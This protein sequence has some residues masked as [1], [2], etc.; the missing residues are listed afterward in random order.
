V[1]SLEAVHDAMTRATARAVNLAATIDVATVTAVSATGVSVTMPDG[2]SIPNV[3]VLHPYVA[4][5]GDKVRVASYGNAT[6]VLGGISVPNAVEAYASSDSAF[7]TSSTTQAP[8]STPLRAL[9]VAPRSGI[10]TVHIRARLAPTATARAWCTPVIKTT[11]LAAVAGDTTVTLEVAA[12]AGSTTAASFCRFAGL[13]PGTSYVADFHAASGVS[14]QTVTIS[15]PRI[16]VV[17]ER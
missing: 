3:P 2:A 15:F 11:G 9:F 14:G 10:V 16:Q 7:T 4:R 1:I 8:L 12:G 6:L 17:P 5:V 13:T